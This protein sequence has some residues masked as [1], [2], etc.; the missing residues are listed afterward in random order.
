MAPKGT[1]PGSKSYCPGPAEWGVASLNIYIYIYIYRERER[2]F[3]FSALLDLGLQIY[4]Y[5][6]AAPS[7]ADLSLVD[8]CQRL[9]RSSGSVDLVYF[10][11]TL[12]LLCVYCAFTLSKRNVNA[13]LNPNKSKQ[14]PKFQKNKSEIS[15]IF[16]KFPKKSKKFQIFLNS[17]RYLQKN[18]KIPKIRR[19]NPAP[20]SGAKLR[21][22]NAC[23]RR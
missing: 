16:Q 22:Q 3:L 18:Q 11:F 19:K 2:F 10:A 15:K 5:T 20:K 23:K 9:L 12:R 17:F 1:F 14:N 8:L 13:H 7:F 21:R 6:I 4:L